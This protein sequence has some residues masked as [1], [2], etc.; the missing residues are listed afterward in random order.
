MA[1]LIFYIA[2]GAAGGGLFFWWILQKQEHRDDPLVVTD[3]LNYSHF[4]DPENG[5][6]RMK[7]G[8]LMAMYNYRGPSLSHQTVTMQD[9]ASNIISTFLSRYGD[10]WAFYFA[11]Q[12]SKLMDYP[13]GGQYQDPINY[14]IDSLR[15]K[16]FSSGQVYYKNK[17][18]FSVV[19]MPGKRP[20]VEEFSSQLAEIEEEFKSIQGLFL[21]RLSDNAMLSE[22]FYGLNGIR[23]PINNPEVSESVDGLIG[24]SDI[25][26]IPCTNSSAGIVRK[27]LQLPDY[28]QLKV[29]DQY[30]SAI[31]ISGVPFE[32]WAGVF[33][34]LNE[35]DVEYRFST[36]VITMDRNSQQKKI[37]KVRETYRWSR[38]TQNPSEIIIHT[39]QKDNKLEEA[40][41]N[42][43]AYS[44][45]SE[46]GN[47]LAQVQGHK[48]SFAQLT[49]TFVI[50]NNSEE[51]LKKQEDIIISKVRK[52]GCV[53][54]NENI[55]PLS[56]LFGTLPGHAEN[57]RKYFMSCKNIADL[58][59]LWGVWS[60]PEKNTSPYMKGAP[61]HWVAVNLPTN[62]T[63]G[64]KEGQPF[65]KHQPISGD[66]GHKVILGPTGSG[67]SVYINFEISQWRRIK[68]SQVFLFDKG[69]SGEVLCQASGGAHY[70][71]G[72]QGGLQFQPLRHIEADPVWF[73]EWI[74]L[75][76]EL[77]GVKITTSQKR[78]IKQSIDSIK[79][80]PA[81]NRTLSEFVF[82]VQD[83]QIR[84]AL[85]VYTSAGKYNILDG[86][87]DLIEDNSYQVF[88]MERLLEMNNEIVLPALDYLFFRVE[89]SLDKEKPT[90]IFVEE[91]WKAFREKKFS[92][93]LEQ[94]LRELRKKNG[95][96]GLITQSPQ[97]ILGFE[98][99]AVFQDSCPERV[100]LANPNAMSS[101]YKELY[102][103]FSLNDT[104]ID[105]IRHARPKRE[106][107]LTTPIGSALID[108]RL[109]DFSLGFL[110]DDSGLTIPERRQAIY[111]LKEE[112]KETWPA[113]WLRKQ[114]FNGKAD[115]LLSN[116]TNK[117]HEVSA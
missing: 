24:A 60:G 40:Y 31:S 49:S 34:E 105:I 48:D 56:A 102:R 6:M 36:R 97:D 95:H 61:A 30:I 1:E 35:L 37:E 18:V 113:E 52:M 3:L 84:Q 101:H 47:A 41:E 38:K 114:G 66:V 62:K 67:K 112:H 5:V 82:Q 19:W 90:L 71:I 16:S 20:G 27:A 51:G 32:T 98:N 74:E 69:Y 108:L 92:D 106:Y 45:M 26:Q 99:A 100:F 28:Y 50:Y 110:G 8:G 57:I 76:V 72:E 4:E 11:S 54:V 15:K 93:R 44:M 29:G 78:I 96:V 46:A 91:A 80:L 89:Q 14:S 77:Q 9:H 70:N 104:Q 2:I 10:G 25:F 59:P 53:A 83:Q 33:E 103:L 116:I 79:N 42:K 39:D 64:D 107:Y 81:E 13:T 86:E 109:D 65:I 55:Q 85:M 88:E 117:Q 111:S 58:I 17:Y 75:M 115:Y 68:N 22:L 21:K 94:W 12:R 73:N 7:D 63:T 43:H 23:Q 87:H